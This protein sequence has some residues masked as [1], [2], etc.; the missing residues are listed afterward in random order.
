MTFAYDNMGRMRSTKLPD[1]SVIRYD[2]DQNGSMT[3]LTNPQNTDFTFA[4]TGVDL[5]KTTYIYNI[6]G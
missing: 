5:R 4:Y 2:Y 3:V 1:N 6:K